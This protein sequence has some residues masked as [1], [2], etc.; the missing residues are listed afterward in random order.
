[1]SARDVALYKVLNKGKRPGTMPSVDDFITIDRRKACFTATFCPVVYRDGKYKWLVSFMAELVSSPKKGIAAKA[2]GTLSQSSTASTT[3]SRYAAHSVLATGK[4]AKIRVAQ[5]GIHQL[6][7]ATIRK[8]GFS[9]PSKVKIYGYG[10]NLVPE[11]LTDSYLR[12]YDDLKEVATCTVGG[13][14]LFYAKGSVSWSS[15]TEDSKP[16][17]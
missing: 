3:S 2:K 11:T 6:T 17:F 8:A 15:N 12:E 4:W 5:S 9:D 13:K 7:D 14:R 1:M 16:I 10:G